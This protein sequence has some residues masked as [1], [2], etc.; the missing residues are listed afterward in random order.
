MIV[1]FKLDA[2]CYFVGEGI[3]VTLVGTFVGNLGKVVGFEFDTIELIETAELLNLVHAFLIAD[4]HI[5]VFVAGKLLK[6]V[7]LRKLLPVLLLRT[8]VFGDGEVGHN[9]CMVDGVGF[10][11]VTDV[12][13]IG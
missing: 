7:L 13:G 4:Y 10:D 11:F 5:A 1:Q 6:E 8:K 3:A 2:L 12:A 9:R